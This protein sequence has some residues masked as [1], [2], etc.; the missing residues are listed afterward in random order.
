MRTLL[1]AFALAALPALAD[2]IPWYKEPGTPMT[3]QTPGLVLHAKL[4]RGWTAKDDAITTPHE[5]CTMNVQFHLD[6][7]W[8]D[9]LVSTLTPDSRREI[10]LLNDRPAVSE[11]FV[12]S[13]AKLWKTYVRIEPHALV[14]MT[15]RQTLPI[16]NGDCALQYF[17]FTSSVIVEPV[18]HDE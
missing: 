12:R 5:G 17:A 8:D 4:P 1:L 18:K 14:T 13:D 10:L 7:D 2:E 3:L 15:L 6:R 11:N 16:A 9:F